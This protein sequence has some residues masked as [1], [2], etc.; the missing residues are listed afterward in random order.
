LQLYFD[1]SGYSDMAVGLARMFGIVLPMNFYSPYKA[2]NIIEFWHRWHITLSRFLRDYLYIPLGGNR[3]GTARRFFNLMFTMFL[4]GLWHGAGW[5]FVLWGLLH[6]VYLVINHLWR[7]VRQQLAHDLQRSTVWGRSI[8][9]VFTFLAIVIAWVLF[10]AES[11]AGA[12]VVYRGMIGM[13]GIVL[14]SE[15]LPVL[16]S[17]G[18]ILTEYGIK[19]AEVSLFSTAQLVWLVL[20]LAI[21]WFMPNIYQIMNQV[22][23]ALLTHQNMSIRR[24]WLE[25]QPTRRWAAVLA[26]M[27]ALAI[28]SLTRISEFLYFQF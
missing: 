3:K 6:G 26:L 25:W 10:R 5:T 14:S 1:F 22:N 17:Y 19:F 16:G 8:S 15:Y 28:L 20:L 2:V 27:S 21:V 9:I 7:Q 11:M 12:M 4:G 24:H 23:P 13:N 18:T